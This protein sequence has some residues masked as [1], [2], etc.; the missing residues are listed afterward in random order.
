[1]LRYNLWSEIGSPRGHGNAAVYFDDGDGGETV[2]GN[3]FFVAATPA[4]FGTVFSHGG[5]GNTVDNRAPSVKR[6]VP[7][8]GMMRVEGIHRG[9]VVQ[10]RLLKEVDI[11]QP[12]YTEAY[13][14]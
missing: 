7:L 4:R 9:T 12:P 5:H 6:V 1:M 11:T 13:R 10:E 8:R 2:Y 14:S 3:L